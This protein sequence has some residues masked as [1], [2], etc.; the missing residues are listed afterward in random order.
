LLY[1]E[2]RAYATVVT[3][4]GPSVTIELVMTQCNKK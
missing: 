3:S 2:F 4:V 1:I